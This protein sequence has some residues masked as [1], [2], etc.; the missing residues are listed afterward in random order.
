[1]NINMATQQIQAEFTD[2][3][4]GIEEDTSM[5]TLLKTATVYTTVSYTHLLSDV[6]DFP[7][8]DSSRLH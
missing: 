8:S 4:A 5:G 7:A 6:M 3:S 1:M 2:M